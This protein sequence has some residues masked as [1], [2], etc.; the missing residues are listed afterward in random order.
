MGMGIL[1]GRP[2]KPGTAGFSVVD[3]RLTIHGNIDTDGTVR[4]DGR[5]EGSSHRAGTLIV[6]VGG[7]VM[8]DVEA[9]EVIVA[10]MIEGNVHARGRIEIESGASVHGHVRASSISLREGGSVDGRVS[11]SAEPA[12][13]PAPTNGRRL[14]LKANTPAASRSRG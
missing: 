2:E 4:V 1:G 9:R 12:A 8:G 6:G 11:I 14:E 10:G 7:T 5:V 3:D 13:S